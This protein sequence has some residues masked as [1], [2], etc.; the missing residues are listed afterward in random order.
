MDGGKWYDVKFNFKNIST[1]IGQEN[2]FEIKIKD[3]YTV[4]WGTEQPNAAYWIWISQFITSL[5]QW[6]SLC[7][8]SNLLAYFLNVLP[9]F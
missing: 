1:K 5:K 6:I 9:F 3:C 4:G 2:G 7:M 8:I